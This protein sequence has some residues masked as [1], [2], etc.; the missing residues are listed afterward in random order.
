MSVFTIGG[1]VNKIF[2]SYDIWRLAR[3]MHDEYETIAKDKGWQ[4][5]ERC[6]VDFVDLPEQNKITMLE[7]ATRILVEL[8]LVED[9]GD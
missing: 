1:S 4:T 9:I 7:L 2:Y 8:G 5:Q 3:F 6:R